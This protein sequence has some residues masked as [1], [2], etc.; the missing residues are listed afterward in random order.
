MQKR[1]R[2]SQ[3][4]KADAYGHGA[5]PVAHLIEDYDYIWGFAAATA[6]EAIHLREAGITKPILILGIVFDEYFPE[7]VRYEI[8]PAVCE[9]EE[10][11]KLSDEA[12]LQKKTVHI[13]IALDTGMTRIGFA[14]AQENVEEIKKISELPNLEI[15]GMFTHFARADEYD[16]SP[17]MVQLERYL[18][19]SRRV[20]EAGVEIP[21]HHCSNSAG[22]IRM[23]EA[24][25]NIVRA[26]ITIYGIY[27]SSEVERDI[28]KLE[29]VM[30]LKESCD[31]CE[32]RSVPEQRSATAVLMWL[33]GSFVDGN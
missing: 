4:S 22:I 5:V 16:R 11:R 2:S 20:E 24:N 33:T 14:D 13:H 10:A 28:V 30:E 18:D 17:A 9:Y 1:Q 32:G 7:L 3:S 29:P 8:R 19:F 6:E 23:P 25:L 27:P 31:L 12:V 26:G 21:L 15:E